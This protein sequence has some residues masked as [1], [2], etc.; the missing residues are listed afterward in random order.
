M[1]SEAKEVTSYPTTHMLD[2]SMPEASCIKVC[3]LLSWIKKVH[4]ARNYCN[5]LTMLY[6]SVMSTRVIL[7][8]QQRAHGIFISQSLLIYFPSI[9][10][11]GKGS[12]GGCCPKF[13]TPS[14]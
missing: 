2:S 13:K 8:N 14:P 1:I 6:N 9:L 5:I 4:N 7:I 10:N 12:G 11:M 3:F